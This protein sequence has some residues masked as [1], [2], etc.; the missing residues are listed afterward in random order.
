MGRKK[1]SDDKRM[2]I[3]VT[4]PLEQYKWVLNRVA[5]KTYGGRSHCIELAIDLLRE[6]ERNKKDELDKV[7]MYNFGVS[8]GTEVNE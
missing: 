6:E 7:K 4:L 8:G 5:D 3:S 2:K 1:K